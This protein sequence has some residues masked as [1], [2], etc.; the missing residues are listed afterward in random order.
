M[1]PRFFQLIHPLVQLLHRHPD[2]ITKRAAENALAA[3]LELPD[4]VLRRVLP[5]GRQ[6]AFSNRVGWAHDRLKRAKLSGSK[7]WGVWQLTDAGHAFAETHSESIPPEIID[8]IK[9]P[10]RG[11]R[12]CDDKEGEAAEDEED[13]VSSGSAALK[14]VR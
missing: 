8:R 7:S 9:R 5:S 12:V 6:T 11:S 3:E 2:G 1:T 10:P 14:L 13:W 4:E